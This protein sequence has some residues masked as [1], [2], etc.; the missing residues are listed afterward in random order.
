MNTPASVLLTTPASKE[1]SDLNI[2]YSAGQFT[3]ISVIITACGLHPPGETPVTTPYHI[4]M[5]EK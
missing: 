3:Y 5:S 1:W 4:F 2:I